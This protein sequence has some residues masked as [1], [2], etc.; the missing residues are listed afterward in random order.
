MRQV[1]LSKLVDIGIFRI[2]GDRAGSIEEFIVDPNVGIVRFAQVRIQGDQ[3]V[4]LPWAAMTYA[5]SGA[6]FTLTDLGEDLLDR[7]LAGAAA[8]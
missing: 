1:A 2:D 8:R 4:L 3:L 5:K 6:G 7:R